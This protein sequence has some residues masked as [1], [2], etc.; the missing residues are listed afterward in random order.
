[1]DGGQDLDELPS[2]VAATSLGEET[3][4]LSRPRHDRLAGQTLHDEEA[5]TEH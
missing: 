5:S 2:D 1:M 3:T 4:A